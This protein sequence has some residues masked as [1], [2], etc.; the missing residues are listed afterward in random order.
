MVFINRT[1]EDSAADAELML[2]MLA[3]V[4][5]YPEEGIQNKIM[6]ADINSD[7]GSDDDNGSGSGSGG[8]G[9]ELDAGHNPLL[10][11]PMLMLQMPASPM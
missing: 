3:L 7:D 5:T 4:L 2:T 8:G 11:K 6:A 10:R 9:G 1:P